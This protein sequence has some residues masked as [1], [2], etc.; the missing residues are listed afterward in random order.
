MAKT[1]KTYEEYS[2][3]FQLKSNDR[4][5]LR[6]TIVKKF[7]EEKG[8]YWKDGIKHVTRFRY[9]VE[10]LVDG[11]RI[12][13]L[14]PTHLN[15]GIDFQV[16]VEK[17]AED[18]DGRPSHKD[19]FADLKAKQMEEPRKALELAKLIERI[20]HCEDPEDILGATPITFKSGWSAEM[21][22]KILK[23]LFIEQDITYW[24]YDGRGMLWSAIQ[25]AVQLS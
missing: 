14:R 19:V 25:T 7:L 20:W 16:W 3:D 23:W 5:E 17:F 1:D 21:M 22:L 2:I 6:D 12:F 4:K 24:N 9:Y 8:G 11:R 18:K 15:K 10:K 13:L